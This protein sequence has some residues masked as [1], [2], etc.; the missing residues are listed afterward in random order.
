MLDDVIDSPLLFTV[1][2]TQA[3]LM[4][5][6]TAR[7]AAVRWRAAA[8][9]L[10]SSVNHVTSLVTGSYR[11]PVALSAV[12][13][14]VVYG[15]AGT[16]AVRVARR[17]RGPATVAATC[18]NALWVV[19]WFG[20]RPLEARIGAGPA[21]LALHG[22]THVAGAFLYVYSDGVLAGGGKKVDRTNAWTSR[23]QR[24]VS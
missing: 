12:D 16:M 15:C 9:W 21:V 23:S 4:C 1:V 20:I 19:F 18:V 10:V 3:L 22:L 11:V 7:T 24:D 13:M 6:A 2:T 5:A 8:S 14:L 17:G